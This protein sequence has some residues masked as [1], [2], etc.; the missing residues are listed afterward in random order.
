MKMG[1]KGVVSTMLVWAVLLL[2]VGIIGF[3][4]TAPKMGD[5]D[6]GLVQIAAGLDKGYAQELQMWKLGYFGSIVVMIVGALL[7]L[8]S[9]FQKPS[10]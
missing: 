5:M 6:N 1:N 7:F 10:E 3:I 8:G 9:F 2:V 4:I